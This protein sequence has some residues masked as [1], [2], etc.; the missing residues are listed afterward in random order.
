LKE[1]IG[2]I[3]PVLHSRIPAFP[4]TALAAPAAAGGGLGWRIAVSHACVGQ[5]MA[6]LHDALARLGEARIELL[7]EESWHHV[8]K[9]CWGFCAVF[10][11][12]VHC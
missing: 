5:G 9:Y 12:K 8:G 2:L 10:V 6:R 11:A 1:L 3:L 4:N 7:D